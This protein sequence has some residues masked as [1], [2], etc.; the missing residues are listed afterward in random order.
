MN[1]NAYQA[2]RGEIIIT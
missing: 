2:K 1:A